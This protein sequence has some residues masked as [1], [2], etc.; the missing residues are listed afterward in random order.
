MT[1]TAAEQEG[2]VD[3]GQALSSLLR[4][5]LVGARAAIDHL[6]GGPRGFQVLSISAAGD[7]SNQAAIAHRLGI[8]RTVMTYLVDDLE[9]SGL[10]ERR[11]DP[12]DRRARQVV[13]TRDG[14]R[15]LEASAAR[16]REVEDAVLAGLS[17]EDAELFRALL[18]RVTSD[19]PADHSACDGP[20][21][22]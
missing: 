19:A 22:C 13:L 9:K 10:V 16:L 5:Y 2:S 1:E 6:P 15:E 4:S 12:A 14:H 21:A 17:A 18:A 20:P 8:D 7:C 11:P 3:F